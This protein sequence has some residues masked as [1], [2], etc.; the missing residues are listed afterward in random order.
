AATSPNHDD[1]APQASEPGQDDAAGFGDRRL[2][3]GHRDDI[4]FHTGDIVAE[5]IAEDPV[6]AVSCVGAEFARR[7]RTYRI[8]RIH[9]IGNRGGL[10]LQT[11]E[12]AKGERAVSHQSEMLMDPGVGGS[13]APVWCFVDLDSFVGQ[14]GV[15]KIVA[16]A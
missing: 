2:G 3:Y 5:G 8:G 11:G 6:E 15:A 10:D 1:D 16:L 4:A 9:E 12:V 13:V 7:P 14:V